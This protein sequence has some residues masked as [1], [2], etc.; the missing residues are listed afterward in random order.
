MSDLRF[1]VAL[2]DLSDAARFLGIGRGRF[3]RWARGYAHG[4]PLL[5]VVPAGPER[6]QVTFIAM[7]EAHVPEAL[8]TAGVREPRRY[9]PTDACSGSAPASSSVRGPR[10]GLPVPSASPADGGLTGISLA[11]SAG[12]LG[13]GRAV[14]HMA[15]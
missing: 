13:S 4:A 1:D 12:P 9:W 2:L 8:S 7:A 5:D 14:R 6:A 10:P 3:Q 11:G 15:S